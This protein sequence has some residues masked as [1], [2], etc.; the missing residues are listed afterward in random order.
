MLVGGVLMKIGAYVLLRMGV[1]ILPDAVHHFST[2]IAVFGVLSIV[3]GGWLAIVQKDWRRL[4]AFSAISHM[5]VMLL[6]VA[7]MNPAGLQG[8]LFMTVSSGLLSGLLFYLLGAMQE[9]THTLEIS[10][11][12]GLSK[13]MPIL[14][15]FLL[16][17]ALGSLGLPGT[18]GFVSEILSFTGSFM[19]FPKLSAVGT[20]GIILAAVYL[21]WAIQRTTF[22]PIQAIH[23]HPPEQLDVRSLEYVPSVVLT[24]LVIMLGLFPSLIGNLFNPTIT[25]LLSRMGG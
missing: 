10:K 3:Y 23:D 17:A 11:L 22:G 5:G 15:G 16:V 13:S 4:V 14:S 18:S 7:A 25:Q 2:M 20:A 8:A 6:G 9:R 24:A 19:L 12:G 1:G 21:L